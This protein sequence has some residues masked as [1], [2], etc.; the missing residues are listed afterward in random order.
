M[1]NRLSYNSGMQHVFLNRLYRP[2]LRLTALLLA[3]TTLAACGGGEP[4]GAAS[5][6][7]AGAS[8]DT[9]EAAAAIDA[10]QIYNRYCFSCHAAGIA[11]APKQGDVEAWK[12]RIAKGSDLLLKSVIDGI[13]PGMPPRGACIGCS[14]EELA[15]AVD[16]MVGAAQ[17]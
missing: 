13:P 10:E 4:A 1:D 2:N 6:A 15:A 3:V 9:P 17:P 14:D 11:G 7:A 12:P 8:P 16:F 5:S